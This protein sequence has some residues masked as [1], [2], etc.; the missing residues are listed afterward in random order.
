MVFELSKRHKKGGKKKIQPKTSFNGNP[1]RAICRILCLNTS[2]LSLSLSLPLFL[3]L[4]LLS[5]PLFPLTELAQIV[6]SHNQ[7]TRNEK[8]PKRHPKTIR[9]YYFWSSNCL[10]LSTA[11]SFSSFMLMLTEWINYKSPWYEIVMV[12]FQSAIY[13]LVE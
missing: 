9:I 3:A 11:S 8:V 13:F 7:T 1:L 4:I 5:K 2:W 12:E 6:L 10:H